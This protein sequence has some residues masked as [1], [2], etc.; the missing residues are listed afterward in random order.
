MND[1]NFFKDKKILITGHTGFKG[2]W[3]CRVL[4]NSGAILTGYS[5]E[6]PTNPNLFALADVENKMNSVIGDI[7]DLDGLKE[8]FQ[9][10]QPEIVI[11]L[12]AQPIVRDSYKDPVYTYETNVMGTVNICECVR[13]NPCVKSFLNVTTDKVYKNNEWVWGY[14]ENDPLDGHDPYSNSKSCS[15]L[16]T[17][18]YI[19]SFFSDGK[20]AISTARAGNVIGG[21]DFANDR[22]V[23]DCVR[24][25]EKKEDIIV[26][27]P[28]STR[29]Y[30]HVLEPVMAYLMIVQKQYEEGKYAGFYNVGP[31]DRDCV[32]TGTLVDLFV[33]KWGE[34]LK[35]VNQYDGGPHEANFLKLDCSKIKNLFDWKP[36]WSVDQA[37]DKTVEWTKVYLKKESIP[38]IMDKQIEDF[39][40][41]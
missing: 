17:H 27:N 31:D 35:W 26:R 32:T 40:K 23:P 10:A 4:I 30:Q 36:S 28:H 2:A 29:P 25:V 8:V 6:A 13:L 3:M 24:A 19:N 5:L 7:R 1:L 18:S 34:G 37:I 14:R 12:A 41:A 9:K 22:I 15:E 33:D 21:G 11:H 20:V 39:L 38:A 16:V